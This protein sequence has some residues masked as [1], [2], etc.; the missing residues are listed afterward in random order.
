MAVSNISH[1]VNCVLGKGGSKESADKRT[2]RSMSRSRP[3]RR[4]PASHRSRSRTQQPSSCH[5]R[6]RSPR[7]TRVRGCTADNSRRSV[8]GGGRGNFVVHAAV[9]VVPSGSASKVAVPSD[10]PVVVP[11]ELWCG[12]GVLTNE[13]HYLLHP[14][15][16]TCTYDRL[17]ELCFCHPSLR[18]LF[19]DLCTNPGGSPNMVN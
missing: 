13:N 18:N 7:A 5:G 14:S 19:V 12:L 3:S 17:S 8:P 10:F 16:A 6:S 2:G 9:D 11:S 1:E 15:D 4:R